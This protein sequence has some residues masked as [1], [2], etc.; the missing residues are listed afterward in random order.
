M[1]E[2][3][4]L[5][6]KR[7][8]TKTYLKT[9]SA[10]ANYK[11]GRII[12]GVDDSGQSV[13]LEDPLG[14]CLSIE[15]AINDALQPVPRFEISVDESSATVS[16]TVYEGASKP[17]LYKGKAYRRADSSTVEVDRLELG[18]L[19]MKGAHT[20]FDALDS[21]YQRLTFEKLSEELRRKIGLSELG[22]DALVS[23]EL[24][25]PEGQ[26]NNAAA[27]LSD[28]NHFPG[29][30]IARFGESINVILSRYTLEKRSVLA[31]QE[32]AM[33]IFDEHYTYEEIVGYERVKKELVPRE[34][35]REAIANALVHR[36]W[37]VNA[38]INVRMFPD[39]IEVTSPGGLPDGITEEMYLAGGPS[40]A[41][42]PILANV[43]FRLGH[44]ERFGTGILRIIEAYAPK[45]VSPAFTIGDSFVSVMLPIDFSESLTQDERSA[46]ESI[47]K[48]SARTRLE[49][50]ARTGM[51]KDK[52]VRI[53]NALIEKRLIEKSGSGR[54][55]RYSRL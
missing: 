54:S 24:M 52:T 30:D 38:S 37:D 35:F 3:S 12:F 42:N 15:N 44:I 8:L 40:V 36:C 29:T 55:T 45:G 31:Q 43:F 5:E 39:R 49:V 11:T 17:Y 19:V 32:E 33:A 34:A 1:R 27:L 47:P 4:N 18:R 7:E 50:E 48:G 25:T 23:L 2:T 16:L 46:L 53:L 9:V 6:F 26:Y 14:A 22:Q 21:N 10:F 41:R 28:E 20:T 13:G 51:S